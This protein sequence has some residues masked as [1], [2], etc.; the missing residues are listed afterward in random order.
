MLQHSGG[1]SAVSGKPDAIAA[2][3][4]NSWTSEVVPA[5]Q[6]WRGKGIKQAWA[7]ILD[8]ESPLELDAMCWFYLD[9]FVSSA[10][11]IFHLGCCL[12]TCMPIYKQGIGWHLQDSFYHCHTGLSSRNSILCWFLTWLAES[13]HT[14]MHGAMACQW[15]QNMLYKQTQHIRDKMMGVICHVGQSKRYVQLA[16][17]HVMAV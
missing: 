13:A 12:Y 9:P 3:A 1:Q 2:A 14:A 6:Q 4:A 8:S 11:C 10:L 16:H 17:V 15:G 7:E 5:E